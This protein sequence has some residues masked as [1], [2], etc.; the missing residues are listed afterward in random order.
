[1][2]EEDLGDHVAGETLA[3]NDKEVGVSEGKGLEIL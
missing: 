3:L 2:D 1:M